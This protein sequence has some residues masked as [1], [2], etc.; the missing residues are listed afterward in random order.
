MQL[1]DF[2]F[3]SDAWLKADTSRFFARVASAK[4]CQD[5][6]GEFLQPQGGQSLLH[7]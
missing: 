3:F 6:P 4:W 1:M 2:W 5:N 7:V